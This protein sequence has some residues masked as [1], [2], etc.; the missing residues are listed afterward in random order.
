MA[1]SVW[2]IRL[3]SLLPWV[4][5]NLTHEIL[6]ASTA[7]CPKILLFLI[8]LFSILNLLK[9][10][11]HISFI[12]LHIVIVFWGY[13][14]NDSSVHW[15]FCA[16]PLRMRGFSAL[17]IPAD[18]FIFDC[19]THEWFAGIV[20]FP[21]SQTLNSHFLFCCHCSDTAFHLQSGERHS[22]CCWVSGVKV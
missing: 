7:N 22:C 15:H 6:T 11:D 20:S 5:L 19:H 8:F 13:I 2:Q 10:E 18:I 12:H 3:C 9:F 17:Q 4:V 1:N 21:I 16:Q 14:W